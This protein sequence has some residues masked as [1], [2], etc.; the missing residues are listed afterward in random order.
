MGKG[1]IQ[2]R[3]YE[4]V[5]E[6]TD[7][8]NIYFIMSMKKTLKLFQVGQQNWSLQIL[9]LTLHVKLVQFKGWIDQISTN[10]IFSYHINLLS[11]MSFNLTSQLLKSGMALGNH[12]IYWQ[13]RQGET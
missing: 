9:G 11:H 10:F 6:L 12:Q 2:G 5:N 13:E 3:A 7:T 4:Y 1:L 8:S